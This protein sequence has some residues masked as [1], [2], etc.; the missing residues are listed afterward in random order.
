MFI[1]SPNTMTPSSEVVEGG[2]KLLGMV[3]SLWV[4]RAFRKGV[5]AALGSCGWTVFSRYERKAPEETE[6][7]LP[8]M[9]IN[10]R[11]SVG[12]IWYMRMGEG[13]ARMTCPCSLTG[14]M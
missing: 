8:G 9:S 12:E 13:V 5:W 6:G 1:A 7:S 4:S 14:G 11:V 2:K 10:M 3:R